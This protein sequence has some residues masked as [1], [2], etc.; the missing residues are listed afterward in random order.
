MKFPGPV[1]SACT[2]SHC[3]MLVLSHPPVWS[4]PSKQSS[5]C[6]PG[7]QAA[8]PVA[9]TPLLRTGAVCAHH[10]GGHLSACGSAA[11]ELVF[12]RSKSIVGLVTSSS[13]ESSPASR[14][15]KVR[16]GVKL[17][18]LLQG[19]EGQLSTAQ[20]KTS[21]CPP[22]R[23]ATFLHA[24]LLRV[25]PCRAMHAP[26]TAPLVSCLAAS[27][28]SVSSG[29]PAGGAHVLH[30]GGVRCHLRSQSTLHWLDCINRPSSP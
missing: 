15:H 7:A 2:R 6:A 25:S 1:L 24:D 3:W 16:Q 23:W 14:A 27:Q 20:D 10:S 21:L 11:C 9:G 17:P 13:L 18:V 12:A 30:R 19:G 28:H 5:Q 4:K 22:P 29:V 8:C 26:G